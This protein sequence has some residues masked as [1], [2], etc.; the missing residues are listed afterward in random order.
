[1]DYSN[2]YNTDNVKKRMKRREQMITDIILTSADKNYVSRILIN[3]EKN[4]SEW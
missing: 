3:E 2:I 1:M 4:G